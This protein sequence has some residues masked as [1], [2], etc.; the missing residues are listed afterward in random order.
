VADASC[1]TSVEGAL[2]PAP[3]SRMVAIPLSPEVQLLGDT[4]AIRG[5]AAIDAYRL[6]SEGIRVV[7]QRDGIEPSPRLLLTVAAL[8]AAAQ[9]SLAADIADIADVREKPTSAPL[10]SGELVGVEEVARMFGI[11]H[12]QARRLAP[13]LGGHKK[14]SG[15]WVFDLG[16][17]RAYIESEK[18]A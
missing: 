17:V 3:S 16:L 1:A 6:M 2:M 10:R 18:S 7:R 15:V 11:G 9:A 8:K 5:A 13:S 12:R 14:R 4:A